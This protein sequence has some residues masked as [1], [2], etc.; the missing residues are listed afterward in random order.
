MLVDEGDGNAVAVGTG[1]TSDAVHVVLGVVRHVVVDDHL[2]VVDVDAT[3]HDVGGYKHV[4]L[5]A[6]KLVHH[7]VALRLFQ[8]AVHSSAL[9]AL[10]LQGSRQL[11]HLHLAAAEHDDALQV[12]SLE[13]VLD[14]GHLLSLV[15]YVS[16]LLDFLGR[17]AHGELDFHWVLEQGLRQLLYLLRHGGR[18]HDGLASLRQLGG[19]GLDVLGETHVEHAVGLVE[20]E[21]AHLAQVYVA[22]RDVRDESAWGG[23]HHVGSHA[24]ALELL[25]V[26]V[27][28]VATVYSHAAH[29]LQI[30]AEALHGLVY[31]LCQLAGRRHDDAVDG[32]VGIAAVVELA[33]HRQQVGGSLAGTGLGYAEHVTALQYLW[34]TFF[35]YGGA[36]LES[37]VIQCVEHVVI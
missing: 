21:E 12:A 2:D 11:L 14:D 22:Q 4:E 27:A 9:D 30:I 34:Y 23:Y 32:V 7:L 24:Q 10:L 33:Q 31:L 1:G 19:D 28:V 20:D 25:V 26:A 3:R 18:E 8:V 17:L 36:S 16:L 5:S 15:A 37:H 29:A 6:L 13:D 35:L